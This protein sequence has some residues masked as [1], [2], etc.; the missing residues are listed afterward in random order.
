MVKLRWGKLREISSQDKTRESRCE[1]NSISICLRWCTT[2]WRSE[3]GHY[4]IM[5][6]ESENLGR[7]SDAKGVA[8]ATLLICWDILLANSSPDKQ[9]AVLS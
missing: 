6:R 2:G 3:S 5:S 1:R 7:E 9:H 4:E 8:K